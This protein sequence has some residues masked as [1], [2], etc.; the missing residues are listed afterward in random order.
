MKKLCG[1]A[2]VILP[3]LTEATAMLGEKYKDG[4]YTKNYIEK[5]FRRLEEA[6]NT[7][8]IVLTGVN[9]DNEKWVPPPTTRKQETLTTSSEKISREDITV[10]VMY[11]AVLSSVP[12]QTA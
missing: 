6:T 4:P 11:S 9:L 5:I 12:L 7:K 3:N 1:K 8:K 10:R 2:D